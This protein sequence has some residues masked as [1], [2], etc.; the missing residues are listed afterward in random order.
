[1][2]PSA[3]TKVIVTSGVVLCLLPLALLTSTLRDPEE[4]TG[5]LHAGQA[6]RI[7]GRG[8]P[9]PSDTRYAGPS[10][11]DGLGP[12]QVSVPR[13]ALPPRREL[14]A[15]PASGLAE[16]L[17]G[18]GIRLNGHTLEDPY[19]VIRA[20]SEEG[21]P[22]V[23]TSGPDDKVELVFALMNT[24]GEEGVTNIAIGRE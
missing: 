9:T 11:R 3:K 18:S 15:E 5:A 16:Q 8:K 13:P 12:P 19:E 4:S 22:V 20:V 7:Q 14:P 17:K 21:E 24:L 10:R 6:A 2:K 1:M 23:I